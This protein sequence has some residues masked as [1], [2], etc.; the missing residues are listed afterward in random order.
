MCAPTKL[1]STKGDKLITTN[2]STTNKSATNK[3]AMKKIDIFTVVISSVTLLLFCACS[4]WLL[5]RY[6]EI[7]IDE[8]REISN[9]IAQIEQTVD[10]LSSQMSIDRE[11]LTN[12][13]QTNRKMMENSQNEWHILKQTL[14]SFIMM[15][16]IIVF[17]HLGFIWTLFRQVRTS[18]SS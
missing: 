10:R 17:F 7:K 8:L 9:E 14:S 15:L 13:L 11:A 2:K 18:S 16:F 6:S 5:S 1:C 3:S 12:L 4:Y